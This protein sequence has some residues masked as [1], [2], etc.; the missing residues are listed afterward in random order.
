MKWIKKKRFLRAKDLVNRDG[1][2][3]GRLWR[4]LFVT[5]AM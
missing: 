2:M 4:Q 1:E 3:D 5:G